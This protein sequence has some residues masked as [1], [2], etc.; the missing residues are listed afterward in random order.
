[1]EQIRSG[2]GRGRRAFV[3]SRQGSA[4]VGRNP[5]G[6]FH[7]VMVGG[8]NVLVCD[9]GGQFQVGNRNRS[10]GISGCDHGILDGTRKGI[11]PYNRCMWSRRFVKPYTTHSALTGVRRSDVV[12]IDGGDQ[13]VY[14]CGSMQ[15]WSE[16]AMAR[17][18]AMVSDTCAVRRS[19]LRLAL[20]RESCRIEKR[21]LAPGKAADMERSLPR[22]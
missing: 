21:P 2:S 12:S 1:M 18:S 16:S 19:R 22:S 5:Q 8:K 15:L 13:F 7:D 6:S 14:S 3:R 17:K 9:E 4:I 10:V 11:P 20:L